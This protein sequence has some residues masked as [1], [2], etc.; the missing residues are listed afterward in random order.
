M[1]RSLAD[2]LRRAD[3]AATVVVRDDFAVLGDRLGRRLGRGYTTHLGERGW[4]YDL[5]YQL[6]ACRRAGRRLGELAL[7]TLGG[8]SLAKVVAEVAPDVVVATHPVV[9]AVLGWL[10]AAGR[11]RCPASAV[12]GPL[13]GLGFW[14]QPGVD[15][16]LLNYVEA[17]PEV[18]REVR[19]GSAVPVRPL[20]REEFFGAPTRAQARAQ[21]EIPGDGAVVLI[22]GG[23]W[24]AGDIDGAIDA[25]LRLPDASVIAVT[26]RNDA[27]RA[28]IAD[29]RQGEP[30]VTV[31]GF[32][33]RMRELLA[34]ADVFVTATA[35]VSCLEAELCGCPLVWYGFGV[36]H[37]RDNVAALE[38]HGLAYAA[39]TPE[40]LT[41]SLA[42]A[43]ARGRTD[44]A[45]ARAALPRGGDVLA[46]L[47]A[48]A[49]A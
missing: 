16:H 29:R 43:L 12:V 5:A 27:L 46:A 15:L 21:L 42:A 14:V 22:S 48:G 7:Y 20:V 13:G 8:T 41:T 26:G 35:G 33:D 23:G 25:A 34:A 37:V 44:R 38:R 6:F 31:V 28:A 30:R 1:A 9:N 45:A 24:G 36:G 18:E 39:D 19:P 10:R 4:S 2:D 17:L 3:P 49:R 40:A 47:A 32:T 11:V